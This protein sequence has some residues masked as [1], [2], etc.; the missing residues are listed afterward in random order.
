MGGA[1]ASAGIAG[2][3][4]APDGA[5]REQTVGLDFEKNGVTL[6]QGKGHAQVRRGQTT[7]VGLRHF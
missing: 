6:P 3:V 7:P 4:I 5:A 1:W 2:D